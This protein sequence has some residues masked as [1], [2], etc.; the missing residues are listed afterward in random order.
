MS[1]TLLNLSVANPVID[2][3][4]DVGVVGV[5]FK[6]DGVNV[7]LMVVYEGLVVGSNVGGNIGGGV[8]SMGKNEGSFV[9]SGT[10]TIGTGVVKKSTGKAVG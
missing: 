3:A 7:G 5:Q 6:M 9:G 10:V 2:A 4:T 8:E 1:V